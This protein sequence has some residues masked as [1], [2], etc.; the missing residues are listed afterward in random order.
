M[1]PAHLAYLNSI[2]DKQQF[3]AARC[4]KAH[5]IQADVC[6]YRQTDSFEWSGVDESSE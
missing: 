3:L 6:M 4:N 2:S 1:K 5:D